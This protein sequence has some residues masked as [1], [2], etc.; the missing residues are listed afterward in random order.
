MEAR[1]LAAVRRPSDADV[2]ESAIRG[3]EAVVARALIRPRPPRTR[4]VTPR[5]SSIVDPGRSW[6]PWFRCKPLVS[7][8]SAANRAF[9]GRFRNRGRVRGRE[10]AG[11]GSAGHALGGGRDVGDGDGA[12][13]HAPFEDAA[14][15]SDGAEQGDPRRPWAT[16]AAR[17]WPGRWPSRRARGGRGGRPRGWGRRGRLRRS[18][19]VR[20]RASALPEFWCPKRTLQVPEPQNTRARPRPPRDNAPKNPRPARG[21]GRNPRRQQRG[22]GGREREDGPSST[23]GNQI[24]S[25]PCGSGWILLTLLPKAKKRANLIRRRK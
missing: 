4:T 6:G 5:G 17:G 12:G 22:R 20:A 3:G 9:R 25:P 11:L 23:S 18:G 1:I 8:R 24:E 10:R 13:G 15:A 7:A 16:R 21:V 2:A 14:A 19:R